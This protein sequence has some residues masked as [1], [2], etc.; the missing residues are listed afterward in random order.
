MGKYYHEITQNVYHCGHS[1]WFGGEYL[2]RVHIASTEGVAD[3]FELFDCSHV[4]LLKWQLSAYLSLVFSN[5]N[6]NAH[7]Q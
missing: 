5:C 4:Y 6:S 7:V 2:V 1:H 3:L